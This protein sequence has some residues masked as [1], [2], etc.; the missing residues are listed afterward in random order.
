M[1]IQ[2]MSIAVFSNL[3]FVEVN[4]SV[5]LVYSK[6]GKRYHLPKGRIKNCNVI[7][8]GKNFYDQAIDS[9]I[10]RFEEIRKLTIGQDEDY[11]T[12][13]LLDYD[14]IK[15]HYRLIAVDLSRQ[16]ELGT[17]P[18]AIQQIELVGQLKNPDDAVVANESMFVLTI[19]EK[20]KETRLKFSL[21]IVTVL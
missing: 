20:V 13:C 2:Q 12:G 10:K 5:V 17:D 8:H 15:N 19:L 6:K 18:K 3:N 9:N 1:K 16:R 14:Y 4:R 7:I 11:T 21:G